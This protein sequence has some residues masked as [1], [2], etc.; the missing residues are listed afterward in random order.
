MPEFP[1]WTSVNGR[2]IEGVP[3]IL[4]FSNKGGKMC[5]PCI[6][7]PLGEILARERLYILGTIGP[8][9]GHGD[10][11]L[12]FI[13]ASKSRGVGPPLLIMGKIAFLR[14]FAS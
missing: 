5:P 6:T 4:S 2:V 1:S 9:R 11:M 10:V 3:T 13:G 7:R 14:N 8:T 12:G